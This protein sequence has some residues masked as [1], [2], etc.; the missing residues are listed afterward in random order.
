VRI[1]TV[2]KKQKMRERARKIRNERDYKK[3]QMY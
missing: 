2:G 3:K 1:K